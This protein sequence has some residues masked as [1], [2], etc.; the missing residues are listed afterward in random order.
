LRLK[1]E[2]SGISSECSSL[3]R[4]T[5]QINKNK[6][7]KERL[8]FP[9]PSSKALEGR[10]H[11]TLRM[12]KSVIAIAVAMV[13]LSNN[14]AVAAVNRNNKNGR[15]TDSLHAVINTTADQKKA[16]KKKT[17]KEQP[18]A[19]KHDADKTKEGLFFFSGEIDADSSEEFV[20]SLEKW[21][22]D[23]D[24][25]GLPVRIVMNSP[26]GT[27]VQGFAMIDEINAV[28]RKGHH[29]TIVVYGEAASA[30][31][32]VLQTADTR[33]IGANSWVL[34]HQI[35]S[36]E[37]GKLGEMQ[38]GLQFTVQLQDQFL[39]L[40]ANRSHLTLQ[41]IHN[42]IDNG[43]DW[44]VPADEALKLGLVDQVEPIPSYK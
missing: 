29:V 12:S 23:S 16:D 36:S 13:A 14:S 19:G 8:L 7:S 20:E 26:G 27:V 38:Q 1:G 32:W 44:W 25:D 37:K 39:Q 4:L 34:I 15:T 17:G 35:S 22:A 6:A 41:E 11:M 43:Q 40:L 33:V 42:H 31:G 10:T 9:R 24:N 3:S 28:R 5:L 21:T 30:A 2:H 18:N